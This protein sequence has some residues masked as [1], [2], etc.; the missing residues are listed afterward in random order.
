MIVRAPA[1]ALT[2]AFSVAA[3]ASTGSGKDQGN[4]GLQSTVMATGNVGV[5][6]GSIGLTGTAS[7]EN[8]PSVDPILSGSLTPP[9]V[10]LPSGELD[11]ARKTAA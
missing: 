7:L 1:L 5:A 10:N 6:Q 8:G 4:I 11:T 2:A 3:G 9:T